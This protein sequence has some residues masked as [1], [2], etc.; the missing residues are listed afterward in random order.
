MELRNYET[1]FVLTPVLSE[2]QLQEST[3]KYRAILQQQE[4]EIIH[5]Q[6]IGLKRLAYPIQHKSTGFYN[7]IEFKAAPA[8]IEKLETE[9]KR[10]ERVIRFLTVALDKHGVAYNE[11]KRNEELTQ[12]PE[13]QQEVV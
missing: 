12:T 4:A 3:G 8:A 13:N 11:K 9:Y 5:E 7:F 10:D 6:R 1:T 2:R